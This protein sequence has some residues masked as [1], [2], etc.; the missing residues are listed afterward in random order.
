MMEE[1]VWHKEVRNDLN[2]QRD[3][4]SCGVWVMANMRNIVQNILTPISQKD[5]YNVRYII[6]F[7]LKSQKLVGAQ[8]E[9]PGAKE[10]EEDTTLNLIG[11]RQWTK[12]I[13]ENKKDNTW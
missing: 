7:E 12:R 10:N 11:A 6:A 5:I 4:N 9:S 13:M 8:Q 2:P 1:T 3:G